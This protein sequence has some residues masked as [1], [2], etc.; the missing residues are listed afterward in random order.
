MWLVSVGNPR[1]RVNPGL[2]A[3]APPPPSSPRW[4]CCARPQTAADRGP[5]VGRAL[6]DV[7]N[8]TTGVRSDYVRVL[9]TTAAGPVVLVPVAHREPSPAG[10]GE[11]H[12]AAI[13]DALCVYYPVAGAERA[14][15]AARLLE[16]VQVLAGR[17]SRRPAAISSASL[18]TA[19][20]R[21]RSPTAGS[22][23]ELGRRRRQ[24]LRRAAAGARGDGRRCP[25]AVAAAHRHAGPRLAAAS[26]APLP[27][28]ARRP[29]TRRFSAKDSPVGDPNP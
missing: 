1:R 13:A 4:R 27:A 25:A 3:T 2:S 10:I 12:G 19:S 21:S 22:P 28:A 20:R 15:L 24:L 8:F 6:E 7:N 29:V 17:P 11:R 14:R 9:E 26:L 5:G 23:G 16:P 18:R